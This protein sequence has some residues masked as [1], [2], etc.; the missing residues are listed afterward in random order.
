MISSET[1]WAATARTPSAESCRR[2]AWISG[3]AANLP[4][5]ILDFGG[6]DSSRVLISRGGI[7]MSTGDSPA[8]LSQAILV[9]IILV[10]RLGV[11]VRARAAGDRGRDRSFRT[12]QSATARGQTRHASGVSM[13]I[14]IYIYIRICICMYVYIYIYI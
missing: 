4:A 3:D 2:S 9:G 14:Y 11:G 12:P 5:K 6:S 1:R 10:G 8:S 7:L 13:Y